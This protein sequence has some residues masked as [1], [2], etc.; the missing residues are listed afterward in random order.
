MAWNR[1]TAIEIA[2]AKRS[3][4][5]TERTFDSDILFNM[6]NGPLSHL[7]EDI[8]RALFL[9][10]GCYGVTKVTNNQLAAMGDGDICDALHAV[11]VVNGKRDPLA[12]RNDYVDA[13]IRNLIEILVRHRDAALAALNA[14]QT[15]KGS[16]AVTL[17]SAGP[18]MKHYRDEVSLAG[19]SK[20]PRY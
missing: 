2:Q 9:H 14:G 20:R 18:S 19:P 1:G 8:Y 16:K 17:P 3:H 11:P 7:A 6:R 12:L 13:I 5:A 10:P 15:E 4:M